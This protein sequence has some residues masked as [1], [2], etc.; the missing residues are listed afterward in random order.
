MRLYFRGLIS[1][2]LLFGIS[3]HA[4][5]APLAFETKY[6]AMRYGKTRMHTG[7]GQ[8]YPVSW[9]YQRKGLPVK[10]IAAYDVWRKIVDADGTTGWV[11]ENM[12]SDKR[13]VAVIGVQHT[14]RHDPSDTATPVAL[15]D[16]GTIARIMTCKPGWCQVKF[17]DDD[18]QG[19]MKQSDLWGTAPDES[20]GPVK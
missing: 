10:V 19:W 16:P 13:T 18:Y 4:A 1:I 7:P 9:V 14:L 2:L 5:D 17:I 3:A 12:L 15:A 6:E 8:Q 20:V 11:Q